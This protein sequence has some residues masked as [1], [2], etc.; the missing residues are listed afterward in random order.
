LAERG[1]LK[2]W[3]VLGR[4]FVLLRREEGRWE[5]EVCT[6]GEEA[7]WREPIGEVKG[8]FCALDMSMTIRAR[9]SLENG[10][11]CEKCE[12]AGKG[13]RRGNS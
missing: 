5:Q 13:G 12:E 9:R 11:R 6:G 4:T 1:K 7:V 2:T 10:G 8:T 3:R